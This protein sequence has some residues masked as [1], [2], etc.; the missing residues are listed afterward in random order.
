MTSSKI[1]VPMTGIRV[2]GSCSVPA[3][4]ACSRGGSKRSPSQRWPTGSSVFAESGL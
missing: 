3:I 1:L 4:S 2:E